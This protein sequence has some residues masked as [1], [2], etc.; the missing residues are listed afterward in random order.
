[1][2]TER[3]V[4]GLRSR[5]GGS[6]RV[7]KRTVART[8][9]VLVVFGAWLVAAS[10]FPFQLMP[11]PWETMGLVW[12]IFQTGAVWTPLVRSTL[13]V[14][15]AFV[16]AMAL[17]TTIGVLGGI[18]DYGRR[19]F[20]PFMIGGF[21]IPG[22]AWAAIFTLML[23]IGYAAPVMAAAATTYPYVAVNVWE[24]VQDIEVDLLEMGNAFDLSRARLLKGVILPSIAP[25][26]FNAVR[27]GLAICWKVVTTAEMFA[28]TRGIGA[29][30]IKNFQLFRFEEVWAWA[31]FFML[32][33]IVIEYTIMQPLQRR[34][35]GWRP[36]TDLSLLE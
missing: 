11:F 30:L 13:R 34:V 29:E 36:D 9:G 18:T 8:T 12:E 5:I 28:S 6:G 22:I 35:Y 2:A 20:V 25:T 14:L 3:G 21:T 32:L 17:G 27:Y 7:S 15:G 31:A 4:G 10:L 33:M 26:L 24:A 16:L 23:G 1:M 19:F